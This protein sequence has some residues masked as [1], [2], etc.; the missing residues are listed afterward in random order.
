MVEK[1]AKLLFPEGRELAYGGGVEDSARLTAEALRAD[2]VTIFEGTFVT[3]G[4][5]ARVDI[6]DKRG[7]VFDLIEVK[8]ATYAGNAAAAR[9]AAGQPNLFRSVKGKLLRNKNRLPYL[10]D[11]TFQTLVLRTL[12]P[13]ATIRP[14]L[15]LVD[16]DR[17]SSEDAIHRFFR[18]RFQPA[19]GQRISQVSVEFTGDVERLRADHLITIIDVSAEVD[20]LAAS[21]DAEA[22]VLAA[23]LVPALTR[24]ETAPSVACRE[25][26]YR[27]GAA[28][29]PN[30][31][32]EC[33]GSRSEANPHILD[34]CYVS[35]IGPKADPVPNQLIRKGLCSLYD[36][37]L[38]TLVKKDGEIGVYNR[39]QRIQIENSRAGT[40]WMSD[41]L[42][43][44]VGQ[45]AYPLHF[46]D[47]E[48][49]AL[50]LPYHAGM[51]PYESTAFQWSCHT[52][53]AP[54]AAPI[55][56][57]WLNDT[58]ACPSLEFVHTLRDCVGVD[59]TV[60]MWSH[61]ERSVLR[62]IRNQLERYGLAEPGLTRW[63]VGLAGEAAGGNPEDDEEEEELGG[64]PGRLVDLNKHTVDGLFLPEMAGR[65]SIKWV[66]AA[67]WAADPA[68]RQEFA[69]YERYD[70]GR[71]LSPYEAL[72]PIEIAGA[73]VR[74]KEGTEAVTAYQEMMYGASRDDLAKRAAYRR[75]LLQYCE[76]DTAAMLMIWRHW[77]ALEKSG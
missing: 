11:V 8:S 60:F 73:A 63:I 50:A 55:H 56:S 15:A 12:Y 3:Q 74:V 70:D 34:L 28:E 4:R 21:V 42:K 65:T 46:I 14:F 75:L 67:V 69:Q 64:D 37:P 5:L 32:L 57:E 31:F 17:T 66:L 49:S 7:N 35:T 45:Q 36:V 61:H 77:V 43:Q 30:G 2:R 10:E 40:S 19:D 33:W 22:A 41:D 68:V 72:D 16:R 6:L 59:G 58:D 13:T 24:I 54:G 71:L 23:S 62:Q 47:F 1:M 9:A 53:P 18:V 76:L 27:V 20:E 38:E 51:R 29:S 25:C 48:T 26:E 44:F 52:I 39:R